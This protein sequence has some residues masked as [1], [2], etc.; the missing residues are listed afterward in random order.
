MWLRGSKYPIGFVYIAHSRL[1]ELSPA[2]ELLSF[3]FA[4]SIPFPHFPLALRMVE[5]KRFL[6]F[7]NAWLLLRKQE[8]RKA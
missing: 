7:G 1:P 4:Y 8:M 5:Q 2:A 3:A 6:A